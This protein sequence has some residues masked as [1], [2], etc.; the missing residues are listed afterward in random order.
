MKYTI[1]LLLTL[2]IA[3]KEDVNGYTIN[4]FIEYLQETG[5]YEVI[6]DVKCQIT[7]DVA[8]EV[9]EI[10]TESPH[11]EE[12]VR[13][14]MTCPS[15]SPP[16]YPD[17]SDPAIPQPSPSPADILIS[18]LDSHN[19]PHDKFELLI[20]RLRLKR[21]RDD[22]KIEPLNPIEINKINDNLL[23][24]KLRKLIRY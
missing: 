22:L 16:F 15:L 23:L 2:L 4:P 24:K 12:V 14:F 3:T 8:I 1:I 7:T 13:V 9:C 17:L 19:I 18:I 21:F 20:I 10:L 11:C 5:Y 6:S